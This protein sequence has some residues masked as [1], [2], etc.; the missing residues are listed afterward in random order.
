MADLDREKEY[1]GALKVY[2]ALITA[3]IIADIGGTVKLFQSEIY[4]FTFWL[5]VISI[6]GLAII[7][8]LLAKHM[9]KRIDK[10]KDL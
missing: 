10:L 4:D 8:M 5:G 2:M 7:F 6:I 9:H 1:I 3:L